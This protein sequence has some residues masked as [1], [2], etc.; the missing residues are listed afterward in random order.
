ME[1][2]NWGSDSNRGCSGM[3]CE[4]TGVGPGR[5]GSGSDG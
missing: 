2:I 5:D 4:A 1:R 3:N